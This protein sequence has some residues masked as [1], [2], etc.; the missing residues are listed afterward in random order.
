MEGG[1]WQT[2]AHIYQSP[3]YYIDYTLAQICAFQF[4]LKARQDKQSA[5]NDYVKL[6]KAG[7]SKSFLELVD[8]AGLRS[9]F[10]KETVSEIVHEIN[11]Y[12]SEVDDA[13]WN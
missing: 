5:F 2:Q 4:W 3:F 11:H 13:R 6:C 10:Q 7:G 9:P 12:L 1:F 8:Y